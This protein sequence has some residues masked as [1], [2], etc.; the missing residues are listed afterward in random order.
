MEIGYITTDNWTALQ[1]REPENKINHTWLENEHFKL[2]SLLIMWR[3]ATYERIVVRCG[4]KN[5][6]TFNKINEKY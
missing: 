3:T 6:N 1:G 2:W 4:A 5:R